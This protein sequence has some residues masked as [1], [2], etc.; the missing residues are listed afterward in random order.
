MY[1]EAFRRQH[2]INHFKNNVETVV[3]MMMGTTLS[4]GAAGALSR[5]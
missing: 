1:R 5:N 4:Y 3:A 2:A